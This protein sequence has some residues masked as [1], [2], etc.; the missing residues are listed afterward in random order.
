RFRPAFYLALRDTLVAPDLETA[1]A[2]AYVNGRCMHRIVTKEGQLIERSGTMT[3]GGNTTKR[4]AIK[5]AG[6]GRGGGASSAAGG[7]VSGGVGIVSAARA[8]ELAAEARRA[9]GVVR[10]ARLEKKE[11]EGKVKKLEARGKHLQTLIP[12]LEMRL[13]GVGASE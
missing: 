5:I 2:T 8:E 1:V 10:T 11:A 9:E 12:K 4:G 7:G 3:G 6:G 13:Q